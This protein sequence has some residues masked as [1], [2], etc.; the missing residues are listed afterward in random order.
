MKMQNFRDKK[1][2]YGFVRFVVANASFVRVFV[3][4]IVL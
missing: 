3:V 2:E 4:N 1:A